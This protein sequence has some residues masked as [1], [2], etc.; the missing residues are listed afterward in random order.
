MSKRQEVI[1]LIQIFIVERENANKRRQYKKEP[2]DI[3][4][5]LTQ[6]HIIELIDKNEMV[7]NK[8]LAQELQVSNPG[9]TK[10]MRK[11]LSKKLVE[12]LQIDSNKK[13]I[14]Y[15]LTEKGKKLA[16]I[17]DELH[18]KAVQRY[19]DFLQNFDDKELETI[20]K[21]LTLAIDELK[22]EDDPFE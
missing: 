17:H 14:Y 13:E 18:Q 20:M 2:R 8:F 7:N 1:S 6:F 22:K 11:L 21:F 10:S 4:L 15:H 3:D 19:D 5:S 9:I 12:K 16:F